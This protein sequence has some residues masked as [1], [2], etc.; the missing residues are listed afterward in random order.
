MLSS[1]GLDIDSALSYVF[2]GPMVT[3]RW[4]KGGEAEART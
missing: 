2:S 4:L 3:V 1:D